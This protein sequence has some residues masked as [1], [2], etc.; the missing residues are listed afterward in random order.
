M[1][2]I[3]G[4]A[5]ANDFTKSDFEKLLKL[6]KQSN[7]RGIHSF[8]CSFYDSNNNIQTYKFIDFKDFESWYNSEFINLHIKKFIY[9]NRYSTFGANHKDLL[10]I[11]P[12][13]VGSIS[14]CFNGV[15]SQKDLTSL[16]KHLGVDFVTKND[17][18]LFL[19]NYNDRLNFISEE[20]SF[21]GVWLLNGNMYC[22]RNN[23]R[24]AYKYNTDK[25]LIICSTKD[26]FVRAGFNKEEISEVEPFK[27]I[28]I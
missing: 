14:L 13:N 2:G 6:I 18:E 23:N 25:N 15:L 10:E 16:Q 9:H 3:V 28:C 17:G 1:C 12:I 21:S 8:G 5:S 20:N 11:Q 24:P 7:I 22:L 27:E 26:I 4:Y 19:V